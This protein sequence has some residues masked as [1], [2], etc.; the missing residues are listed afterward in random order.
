MTEI[1]IAPT[2][3]QV[4][5][6]HEAYKWALEILLA[7]QRAEDLD[8][9]GRLVGQ[10]FKHVQSDPRVGWLVYIAATGIDPQQK[11]IGWHFQQT[12]AG[13]IE[14]AAETDLQAGFLVEQCERI[15]RQEVVV[16]FNELLGTIA[17]FGTWLT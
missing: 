5:R 12:P 1:I 14:V 4:E 6:A 10:C 2:A 3:Q 17:R 15:E 8:A 7:A 16:A 9:K 13:Q 11:L